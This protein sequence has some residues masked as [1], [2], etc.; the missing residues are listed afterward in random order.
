[1]QPHDWFSILV[2]IV[3][4]LAGGFYIVLSKLGI[5][6]QMLERR[7]DALDKQIAEGR[8][9]AEDHYKA[10]D[11]DRI[12][13]EKDMLRLEED[14][15]RMEAFLLTTTKKATSKSRLQP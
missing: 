9:R 14:L 6:F 5:M 13:L 15:D 10:C 2:P 8:V 7:I 1:M 4:S 3:T 12:R 11:E